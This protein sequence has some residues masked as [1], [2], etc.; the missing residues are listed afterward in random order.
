MLV[1]PVV[2]DPVAEDNDKR[3]NIHIPEFWAPKMCFCVKHG[4]WGNKAQKIAS[5][6]CHVEYVDYVARIG[7]LQ[8]PLRGPISQNHSKVAISNDLSILRDLQRKMFLSVVM[9]NMLNHVE[10]C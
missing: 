8:T 1:E 3:N 2:A 4:V 10:S 9:L 7:N 5:F 6:S